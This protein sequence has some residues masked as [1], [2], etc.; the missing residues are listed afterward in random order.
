MEL[1]FFE[2][3]EVV[4]FHSFTTLQYKSLDEQQN[5]PN[6]I[7]FEAVR[8]DLMISSNL[9]QHA[10]EQ[11]QLLATWLRKLKACNEWHIQNRGLHIFYHSPQFS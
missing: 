5:V 7:K 10:H 6:I 8:L 1:V 4:D 2:V 3:K 9:R 11:N